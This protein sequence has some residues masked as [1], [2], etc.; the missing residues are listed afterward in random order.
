MP[1]F[2]ELAAAAQVGHAKHAAPLQ[3]EITRAH[4]AGSEAHV[5]SAVAGEQRGILAVQG[6][7]FLVKDEH[8]N[9]GAVLRRVPDLVHLK[10]SGIDAGRA[11]F[12]PQRSFA[13]GQFHLVDG[14][15]DGERLESEESFF[16]VPS[17]TQ[18]LDRAHARKLN[19]TQLFAL[20]IE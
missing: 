10:S 1:F 3:P 6:Q 5:E 11:Y 20:E 12:V 7:P 19:V 2:S 14:R 9:L 15:R 8:R 16:P 13:R 18:S 17:A 4:K